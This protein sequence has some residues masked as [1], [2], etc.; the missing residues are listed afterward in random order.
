MCAS[1][2]KRNPNPNQDA[3][4]RFRPG[5]ELRIEPARPA[6]VPAKQ[7]RARSHETV[8]TYRRWACEEFLAAAARHT[9]QLWHPVKDRACWAAYLDACDATG[10]H[11][12]APPLQP[13][14]RDEGGAVRKCT[15]GQDRQPGHFCVTNCSI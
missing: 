12:P 9:H 2:L 14:C 5:C 6:C 1:I 13:Y 8:T 3:F 4:F 7:T 11:A 10:C 15:P